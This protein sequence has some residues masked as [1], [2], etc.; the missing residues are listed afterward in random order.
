[1]KKTNAMRIL[2]SMGIA[3]EVVSYSWDEEQLDAV[4]AS[5]M[6][7]LSPQQVYKTIVMQD[8]DNQVFV[9]CLPAEF[10]VSLKKARELTQSKD[11]ELIKLDTLQSITGYIRGGCSPLGMKRHFPTFVEEVAQLEE[12]IYVSAGQRGLQLKIQPQDLVVAA[13][14]QFADFT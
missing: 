6:A 8:S 10:S 4:H 5:M 7:G 11:L 12:F 3:Y 1:M 13:Q 9:F 2:E 14:A